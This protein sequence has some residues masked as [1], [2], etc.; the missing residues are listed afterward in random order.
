MVTRPAKVS[1]RAAAMWLRL[2]ID[3]FPECLGDGRA[4]AIV[5]SVDLWRVLLLVEFGLFFRRQ[6]HDLAVDHL[7]V[8]HFLRPNRTM[9]ALTNVDPLTKKRTPLIALV[10]PT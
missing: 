9:V 6:R 2:D 5:G 10:V 8:G 4:V 1:S 3:R 7:V